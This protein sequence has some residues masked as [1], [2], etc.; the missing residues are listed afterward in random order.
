ME[1]SVGI[2]G[3]KSREI[4]QAM[5]LKIPLLKPSLFSSVIEEGRT[6]Y[7]NSADDTITQYLFRDRRSLQ[8]YDP[9]AAAAESWQD[10]CH[11]LCGF[12][13]Q[14]QRPLLSMRWKYLRPRRS[15]CWRIP[16]CGKKAVQTLHNCN[17]LRN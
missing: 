15:L 12:R 4:L 3:E 7:G 9:A 17:F 10:R 14:G 13:R 11:N 8:F 1:K 2:K 16:F 6:F 5:G